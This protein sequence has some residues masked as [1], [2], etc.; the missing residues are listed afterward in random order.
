MKQTLPD[1]YYYNNGMFTLFMPNTPEGEQ[2]YNELAKHTEGTGNVLCIHTKQ[3]ISALRSK[4]YSVK[5]G[6]IVEIDIE[7]L[8]RELDA[9][10]ADIDPD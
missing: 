3:T 8:Y 9:A 10:L 7:E 2:A 6:P 4:G 1:F 5:K